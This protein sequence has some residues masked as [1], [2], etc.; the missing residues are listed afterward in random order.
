MFFSVW[1]EKLHQPQVIFTHKSKFERSFEVLLLLL[2]FSFVLFCFVL[3]FCGGET[4]E[5]RE[6]HLGQGRETYTL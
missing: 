5:S 1:T 2:L 4:S 3:F 6:K